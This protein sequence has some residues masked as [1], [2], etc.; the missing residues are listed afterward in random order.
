[1]TLQLS[2]GE[3]ACS[4]NVSSET[5]IKDDVANL[6]DFERRTPNIEITP[7]LDVDGDQ[8]CTK[9]ISSETFIKD[10]V[11]NLDD[12][13]RRTPKIV[14]DREVAVRTPALDVEVLL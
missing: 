13:E 9:N 8:A 11:A 4:K 10:D 7:A 5:F 1:M 6:N 14:I 2:T 3:Q 12:F